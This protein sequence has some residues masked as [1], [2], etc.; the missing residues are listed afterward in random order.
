VVI[1]LAFVAMTA[2]LRAQAGPE[3]DGASVRR[4]GHAIVRLT[5]RDRA[6][7]AWLE[8]IGAEPLRCVPSPGPGVQEFSVSPAARTA[9]N[10]R[11][12]RYTILNNNIQTMI[13]TGLESMR[14]PANGIAGPASWFD[15]YKTWPQ[16]NSY[17]DDLVAA[18][19][20]LVTKL[21]VGTTIQGRTIYGLRISSPVGANKPAVM[22]TGCQHGREWVA[23]M[24]PM[25]I[26]DALV[27]RYDS[28]LQIQSFVNDLEFFIIP[29]VNPDGYEFT[30][31]V[32]G[33]RLWRKNRRDNGT[34]TVGVDLNRN[35][36]VDW[37]GPHSTTPDSNGVTYFG[38]GPFSEPESAAVRDFILARPQIRAHIDIHSYSQ[39]LISPWH[40]TPNQPTD[41]D[42][43]DS[44]GTKINNAI[45]AVHGVNYA[46]G[47]GVPLLYL[48]SG[49]MPDWC[50]ANCGI[51]SYTLELRDRG[52]TYFQLPPEQII[53]TCQE[54]LPAALAMA[55]WAA[56][57]V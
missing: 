31:A 53:P 8:S 49:V 47:W 41:A 20:D 57:G 36:G 52:E 5:V 27:R 30:Y 9:I 12:V 6:E 16:V 23:V 40:Y 34:G 24:V 21:A 3:S 56:N 11:G 7:L 46:N 50:H 22:F 51:V 42:V 32:G 19:P 14:Q 25:Y 44:L 4:D 2:S 45:F 26:A 55:Q 54:N 48:A 15:N 17:M 29:V 28:D 1:G 39:L 38:T 10:N 18:R 33:D 13:D 35:W 37:G 43:I